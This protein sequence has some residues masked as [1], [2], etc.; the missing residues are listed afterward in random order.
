MTISKEIE[1]FPAS[2]SATEA[3]TQGFAEFHLRVPVECFEESDKFLWEWLT[4]SPEYGIWC[5]NQRD[6]GDE[7]PELELKS[8]LAIFWALF[9]Q[10]PM[11]LFEHFRWMAEYGESQGNSQIDWHIEDFAIERLLTK[12]L[13]R[14]GSHH[15]L[16][17]LREKLDARLEEQAAA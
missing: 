13:C 6:L 7:P 5:D 14:R 10:L 16:A 17:R 12:K 4:G 8:E 15:E 1:I 2:Q 9:K 3:L 11:G